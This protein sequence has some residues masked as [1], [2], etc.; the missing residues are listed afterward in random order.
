MHQMAMWD[1]PHLIQSLS[2]NDYWS[3]LRVSYGFNGIIVRW[4]ALVSLGDFL[5]KNYARLP[6]D[7]LIVEWI[8]RHSCGSRSQRTDCPCA[9]AHSTFRYNLLLHIG[10][11]SSLRTT[12][13]ELHPQCWQLL[14]PMLHGVCMT[15]LL[16]L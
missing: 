10:T 6:P 11:H 9:S 3:V 13:L 7:H 4:D 14:S 1:N 5:R 12:G 15:V 16:S 8:C 2:Y